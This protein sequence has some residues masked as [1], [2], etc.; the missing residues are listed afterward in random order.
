MTIKSD[1]PLASITDEPLPVSVPLAAVEAM[2]KDAIL[3]ILML[4]RN[5]R[6]LLQHANYIF[7]E[8]GE[9]TPDWVIAG[10]NCQK[11]ED[12][13]PICIQSYLNDWRPE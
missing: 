7:A 1:S 10:L 5:P 13:L 9:A 3:S 11:D 2:C 8:R 4:A 6:Y 12:I